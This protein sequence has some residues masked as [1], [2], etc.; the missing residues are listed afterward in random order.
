MGPPFLSIQG[1]T[2]ITCCVLGKG[3]HPHVSPRLVPTPRLCTSVHMSP[4]AKGLATTG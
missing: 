1:W 2:G 3:T 4:L